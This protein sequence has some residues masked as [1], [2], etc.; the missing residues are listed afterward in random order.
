MCNP[1]LHECTCAQVCGARLGRE[2]AA[3][4]GLC[5]SLTQGPG[6]AQCA[7]LLNWMPTWTP[8][9]PRPAGRTR[10]GLPVGRRRPACWP[11]RAVQGKPVTLVLAAGGHQRL[12]CP[13]GP[14]DR[15]AP[16]W[17]M[18]RPGSRGRPSRG[19]DGDRRRD[20]HANRLLR[21]YRF[22]R[23]P[24]LARSIRVLVVI[25]SC[26]SAGMLLMREPIGRPFLQVHALVEHDRTYS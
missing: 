5:A 2:I 26:R 11:D 10:R 4:R 8:T 24:C 20:L 9:R 3:G 19:A 14:A 17:P 22:I 6:S 12:G 25:S 15:T 18:G 16:P 1:D 7:R 21:A 13:V 23:E